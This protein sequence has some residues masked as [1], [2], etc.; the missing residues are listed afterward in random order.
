L[1]FTRPKGRVEND[2]HQRHAHIDDGNSR[3]EDKALAEHEIHSL[4][5]RL[6]VLRS[7]FIDECRPRSQDDAPITRV[8]AVGVTSCI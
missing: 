3:H 4:R 8:L 6:D 7:E 1:V 2:A 5:A